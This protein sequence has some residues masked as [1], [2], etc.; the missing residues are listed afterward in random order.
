MTLSAPSYGKPHAGFTRRFIGLT[1]P[2]HVAP[3]VG[4][5]RATRGTKVSALGIKL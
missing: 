5:I 4:L 2:L 1:R 3:N